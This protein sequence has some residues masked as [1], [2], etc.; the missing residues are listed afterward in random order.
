MSLTVADI[1]TVY[2]KVCSA[3]FDN[4]SPPNNVN[5]PRIVPTVPGGSAY[6]QRADG[7]IQ[8]TFWIMAQMLRF[9]VERCRS[10]PN[11]VDSAIKV[12][13]QAAYLTSTATFN[14][15]MIGYTDTQLAS[16][17][18]T[19]GT[20]AASDDAAWK[21]LVMCDLH[22]ITGDAAWLNRVSS[23]LP[24]ILARYRD[25]DSAQ[26][27]GGDGVRWSPYGIEYAIPG[28]DPNG[29]ERSTL[30]EVGIALA[31]I[32]VYEQTGVSGFLAYPQYMFA[33]WQQYF[34]DSG[35]N[36][37]AYWVDIHLRNS[38]SIDGTPYHQPLRQFN[39]PQD[40]TD[41][42]RRHP[43]RGESGHSS[44]L[45]MAMGVLS[46]KL[47]QITG[48]A[49]YLSEMTGVVAALSNPHIFLM[50]D[51]TILN[52]RDAWTAGFF[53]CEFVREVLS[54]SAAGID[55]SGTLRSAFI[56]TG[57]YILSQGARPGGFYS[58]DWGSPGALKNGTS[59][60]LPATW[61]AQGGYPNAI[62][63]GEANPA[64]M[65]VTANAAIMILAGFVAGSTTGNVLTDPDTGDTL[66]DPTTGLP[67]TDA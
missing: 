37:G 9:L 65:M 38:D 51:G 45:L 55:P 35:D 21:L 1:D 64:Q 16:A 50:P 59:A 32:Y 19:D 15:Q 34:K 30:Y 20:I 48:S 42:N 44:G 31:S 52:D 14:G 7:M 39:E 54:Q 8:G 36:P 49:T 18:D 63:G 10:A 56:T 62:N 67:L 17:G 27:D 41:N 60:N 11:D 26:V 28:E 13:Q 40:L 46:A 6:G 2:A 61:D 24:L 5:M 43:V 58:E 57:T 53:A 66:V 22:N 12:Q 33:V 25:P 4:N 23:A 3:F 47:Y 29:Q